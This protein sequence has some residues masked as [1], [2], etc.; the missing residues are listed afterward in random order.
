MFF[1][2]TPISIF[3]N[4]FNKEFLLLT[5]SFE[6]FNSFISIDSLTLRIAFT[7]IKPSEKHLFLLFCLNLKGCFSKKEKWICLLSVFSCNPANQIMLFGLSP[8]CLKNLGNSYFISI[9][10]F[11]VLLQYLSPNSSVKEITPC[12]ITLLV[13]LN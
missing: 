7:L 1:I 12:Q 11:S 3:L 8:A 13:C 4:S 6:I 2:K 10:A 9:C 5:K